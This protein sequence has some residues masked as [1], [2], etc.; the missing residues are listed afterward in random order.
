MQANY[1]NSE[2]ENIVLEGNLMC[3]SDNCLFF[4]AFCCNSKLLRYYLCEQLFLQ[5]AISIQRGCFWSHFRKGLSIVT[6]LTFT[7]FTFSFLLRVF[8]SNGPKTARHHNYAHQT[9]S[10]A[11][12]CWYAEANHPLF[13]NIFPS[14]NS[15]W[16][17][18]KPYI[19]DEFSTFSG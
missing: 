13:P 7:T 4:L 5:T 15:L 11:P 12:L 17:R 3:K 1:I 14:P 2:K 10:H 8:V 18:Y 16:L 9:I 19:S 6:C